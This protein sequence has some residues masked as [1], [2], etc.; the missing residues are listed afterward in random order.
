MKKEKKQA[1]NTT[2][3][4]LRMTASRRTWGAHPTQYL[5]FPHEGHCNDRVLEPIHLEV[6]YIG[7]KD[8]LTVPS[9]R[10]P[11]LI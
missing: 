1:S 6:A 4:N 2:S 5:G 9:E 8:R 7:L 3:N 10:M 11:R